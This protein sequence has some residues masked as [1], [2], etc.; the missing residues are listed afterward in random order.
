[1]KRYLVPVVAGV[2]V[3]GAATAF[4]ASL[5]VNSTTLGSGNDAVASCNAS[6]TIAY[7]PPG[8]VYSQSGPYGYKIG[9]APVT[10]AASCASMTYKVTLTGAG[11]ASLAERRARWTSTARRC[12][13][14]PPTTSPPPT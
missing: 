7:D 8:A 12:R 11:N 5:T 2:A 4:A 13:T 6:A 10:S 14:S 3:F 9:I 1:M